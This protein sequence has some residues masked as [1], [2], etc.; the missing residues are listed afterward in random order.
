MFLFFVNLKATKLEIS[1]G[2][3]LKE[4]YPENVDPKLTDELPHFHLYVRQTQSQGLTDEQ[5]IFL[6]HEDL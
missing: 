5:S 2:V 4:A 6:S 1:Q 3:L